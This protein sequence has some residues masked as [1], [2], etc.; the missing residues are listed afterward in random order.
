[1][2]SVIEPLDIERA[3]GLVQRAL[4]GNRLIA[5]VLQIGAICVRPNLRPTLPTIA[6]FCR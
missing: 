4:G 6:R 5:G 1:M 3:R 2:R